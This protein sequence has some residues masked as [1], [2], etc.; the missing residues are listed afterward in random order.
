[1]R[2]AAAGDLQGEGRGDLLQELIHQ[3][4]LNRE[5]DTILSTD[6]VFDDVEGLGRIDPAD[7]QAL[8]ALVP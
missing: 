2:R 1:V 5:I 8:T 4:A 7:E 6:R 3:R